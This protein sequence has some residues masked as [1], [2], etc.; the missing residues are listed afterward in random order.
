M[1]V[2]VTEAWPGLAL[3]QKIDHIRSMV[4]FYAV[5]RAL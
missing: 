5:T 1:L 3:V 2:P 4:G